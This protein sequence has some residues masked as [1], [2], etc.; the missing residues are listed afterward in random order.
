MGKNRIYSLR[1]QKKIPQ[2][3]LG[4]LLGVSQQ[5]VSKIES[6]PIPDISSELLC[7]IADYFGVTADYLMERSE[8]SCDFN[9]ADMD[10]REIGD[11]LTPDDKKMWRETNLWQSIRKKAGNN[12]WRRSGSLRHTD[13]TGQLPE[14]FGR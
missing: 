14:C 6:Q 4:D 9:F 1:R 11:C 5:T 8:Q 13:F 12:A 7:R 10:P 2:A 3:L